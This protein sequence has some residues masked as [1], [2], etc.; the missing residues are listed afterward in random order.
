MTSYCASSL[1]SAAFA[2]DVWL[3]VPVAGPLE[4]AFQ[5]HWQSDRLQLLAVVAEEADQGL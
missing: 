4:V 2:L 5:D 1:A 3:S